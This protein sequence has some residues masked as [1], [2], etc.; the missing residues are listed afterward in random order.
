MTMSAASFQYTV[1]GAL[2]RNAPSYVMRQA[3]HDLYDALK[4]GDYCYVF[5]SRQMGKSSLRVQVTKRLQQ[6][7]ILCAVLE[8]SGIA[9]H[10]I[11]T[12]EW[13]L[14]LIH[15][16]KS[17]V[18]LNTFDALTWWQKRE[19]LSL[20]QR[21][22]EF[23]E[24]VLLAQI[25]QPIVIFI[26]EIDYLFNFDF[27]DDF[28]A[29]IRDY[30]QR[31]AE[32]SV[33]ERLSF[34]LL[35]V[36]TPADLIRDKRRTSFNIGGKFID[37]KGFQ[38][39]EVGPLAQGLSDKVKNTQAVLREV[40]HWTEG[41]PFLTQKIC[42]LIAKADSSAPEGNETAW[43][44]QLIETQIIDNWEIHDE[45]E[46]LKTI[47]NRILS[48]EQ[49]AG[50]LLGLYQHVLQK[51]E[52]KADGSSEQSELQL[53]GLVVNQ[54]GKLV[55]RNRIYE[56]IFNQNWI[57]Y[58]LENLRPYAESFNA[59]L[60]S[61]C[62]DP[63]RLLRGKALQDALAWAAS[64][65]LSDK[66]YQYLTKSQEI[67]N[68]ET[69]QAFEAE[70]QARQLEKLESE[71]ILAEEK[72]RRIAAEL[73]QEKK[74]RKAAQMKNLALFFLLIVFVASGLALDAVIKA[75][76]RNLEALRNSSLALF[77]SHQEIEALMTGVKAG[78]ELEELKK[79]PFWGRVNSDIEFRVITALQT[80][81]YGV[82]ER[83]RL[84]PHPGRI[85]SVAFSDDDQI[86]ASAS[87]TEGTIKLWRHDGN[88]D[89][90]LPEKHEEVWS[91]DFSPDGKTLASVSSDT[92]KLW[93]RGA[94]GK[95]EK[96]VEPPAQEEGEL[97][98]VAFN[99]QNNE[100]VATA[101][102]G[103]FVTLWNLDGTIRHQFKGD[104]D[105]VVNTV[106]FSP[107]GQLIASSIDRKAI[108][109]WNLEDYSL[110][111]TIED[112]Q[113]LGVRF[114][115]DQTIASYGTDRSVKLR[116]LNGIAYEASVMAH[117]DSIVDLD[118]GSPS[119]TTDVELGK[120][121]NKII[122]SISVDGTIKIWDLEGKLLE[123]LKGF[124]DQ[125][126]EIS[127]SQNA[128]TVISASNSN[129]IRVWDR[130]GI[131]SPHFE[132]GSCFSLGPDSQTL[133]VGY[134]NGNVTIFRQG[135]E[136]KWTSAKV[137]QPDSDKHDGKVV[138]VA[139]NPV[140]N[141]VASIGVDGK[142]KLW[143]LSGQVTRTF[144]ENGN[145]FNDI[146]FSPDGK[147]IATVSSNGTVK[148]WSLEGKLIR[149]LPE[150]G[151]A[152]TS[153]SFSPNGQILASAT[154]KQIKLWRL[155]DGMLLNTIEGH[156]DVINDI[157][158]NPNGTILASASNDRTVKLWDQKG[159][160]FD[161][162]FE[163]HSQGVYGVQFNPNGKIL[164]SASHDGRIQLWSL[165]GEL[166]ATLQIPNLSFSK[167]EFTRNGQAFASF[168]TDQFND[169][170]QGVIIW[171]LSLDNLLLESCGWLNEYLQESQK[172]GEF[173]EDLAQD[174]VK[175]QSQQG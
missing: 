90:E 68:Q 69:Q 101:G 153:V 125:N 59:W 25:E 155:D 100:M 150:H 21:F 39:H 83:N 114:I 84:G 36:A 131:T 105:E 55:V 171:D 170:N 58:E 45:P 18:G 107:N 73:E 20:I 63:S 89:Q 30:Y 152:V 160:L 119:V 82:K 5:N 9:S 15:S 140:G 149:T 10:D 54:Q 173:T 32:N 72:Q 50:R 85:A 87:R 28:F 118:V 11:T 162:P 41:Q 134:K 19:G 37:L 128:E 136:K 139:F 98:A 62:Q 51:E 144:G 116:N 88:L 2:H 127:L 64:K 164:A 154:G 147:I 161:H 102:P 104:T 56:I 106:S 43:V 148:L 110:V 91:V 137:D 158:F 133:A 169:E 115:D 124:G 16:F 132:N 94:D 166:L 33:Y 151:S 12:S 38:L 113:V 145:K 86:I 141:M 67:D 76:T 142:I 108:K 6:E 1:G 157:S 8:V 143:N 66:D 120:K 146:S 74:R 71:I 92:L 65:S 34:V 29:L 40:L 44:E 129:W 130:S 156:Q 138:E 47:R 81:V 60:A 26:D 123:T 22:D 111:R 61:H 99:P 49:Q 52:V 93:Q 126:S 77:H 97:G 3:D 75:R 27:N 117:D 175:I 31:R 4:S 14:G 109:I 167:I 23:I 7:G 80:V 48:N 122:A 42:Q 159:R 103:K 165:K 35:G 57:D 17:S 172:K 24:G 96:L 174:C 95:F 163:G 112:S 53:S 13:Y 121:R 168:G 78:I 46:H 135:S 70:K 79:F